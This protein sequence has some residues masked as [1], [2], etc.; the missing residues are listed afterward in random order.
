MSLISPFIAECHRRNIPVVA[1]H[2]YCAH[3]GTRGEV[4]C[5]VHQ[6]DPEE[7]VIHGTPD[8]KHIRCALPLLDAVQLFGEL[9]AKPDSATAV[10]TRA[11]PD[12]AL[13]PLPIRVPHRYTILGFTPN[14]FGEHG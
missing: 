8:G 3:R 13:V 7:F 1:L 5:T 6:T 12:G 14:R 2:D 9:N 11:D 10:R 4:L